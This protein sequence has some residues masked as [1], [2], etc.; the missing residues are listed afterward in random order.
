VGIPGANVEAGDKLASAVY[1]IT[2]SIPFYDVGPAVQRFS[3]VCSETM[4]CPVPEGAEEDLSESQLEPSDG[5]EMPVAASDGSLESQVEIRV[6]R[7]FGLP[8]T[9]WT[10]QMT[11]TAVVQPLPN[12]DGA[13]E[14]ELVIERTEARDST[15]AQFLPQMESLLGAPSGAA[16]EAVRKGSSFVRLRS[17]FPTPDVRISRPVLTNAPEEDVSP[18]FVYVR[19]PTM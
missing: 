6:G 2:D 8:S 13:V 11:T 19:E 7:L 12:Q 10:T 16:L 4:G 17:T 14:V 18:V 3:G 5:I 9:P 15:I 1:G